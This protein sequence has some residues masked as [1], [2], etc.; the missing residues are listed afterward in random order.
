[1]KK[2]E[3]II[4]AVA[5]LIGIAIGFWALGNRGDSHTP[6]Q[7]AGEHTHE[8]NGEIWTC[9]MHPQI[10]QDEPGICPICEMDLI[11]MESYSS[12][13]PLQLTM[14]ENAV[15]IAQLATSTVEAAGDGSGGN[16]IVVSGHLREDPDYSGTTVAQFPGTLQKLNIKSEGTRVQRGQLI[17]WIHAPE[18]RSLQLELLH[19]YDRRETAPQL[20]DAVMSKMQIY[21]ID[22]TTIRDILESGQ[23]RDLLPVRA[24]Q[25]G[26][27]TELSVSEGDYVNRGT[28]I[29]RLA[30]LTR[31]WVE[32]E[33]HESNLQ[34]IRIGDEVVF[35][36]TAR[37]SINET[38]RIYYI[39]PFVH[40]EK[41][42]VIV[43]ARVRN[44]NQ[45]FKPEMLVRGQLTPTTASGDHLLKI[46]SSAVLWTGKRSVVYV[47]IPDA[48]V[49]TFEYRNV[50]IEESNRGYTLVSSGLQVGEEVVT[51]GAFTVDA[52]AQLNNKKSMMN[53]MIE[54]PKTAVSD[55]LAVHN[56]HKEHFQNAFLYYLQ[57]KD[58]LVLSKSEEI[59]DLA[60]NILEELKAIPDLIQKEEVSELW[61]PRQETAEKAAEVL[62]VESDL[63]KQRAAF[64]DLSNAVIFWLRHFELNR[65]AIYIQNCPMAFDNRGADWISMESEIK[66]PYFGDRMLRCG[67]VVETIE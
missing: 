19:A 47:Q 66:N 17:G 1:M 27:V 15:R 52:A 20:Y 37:P 14:T 34:S 12:D 16:P 49:P 31:L 26:T 18:L 21:E 51:Q 28:P 8:E 54:M 42:T 40:P 44:F 32:F 2:K 33:V 5:L 7:P 60:K 62:T 53:E 45:N 43:R 59:G 58:E 30:N 56:D 24:Q 4:A 48:P 10:R 36:T 57:L 23:P 61:M 46:P 6:E 38:V 64:E 55:R 9:S 65:E 29:L 11:P 39:D 22:S 35:S 50:D 13:D 3:I 63:E 25:S 67:S 41:R